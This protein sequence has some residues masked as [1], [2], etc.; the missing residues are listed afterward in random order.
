MVAVVP[1][2]D[3]P[4][5]AVLPGEVVGYHGHLVHDTGH[6]SGD[7]A[8]TYTKRQAGRDRSHPLAPVN[9]RRTSRRGVSWE[10]K[11]ALKKVS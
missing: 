4:L 11:R 9:N 6:H 7:A 10:R 3:T 5:Y 1:A 8:H 2:V